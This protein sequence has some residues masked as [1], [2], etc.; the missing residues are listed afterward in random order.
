MKNLHSGTSSKLDLAA[1]VVRLFGAASFTLNGVS[2]L[3]ILRPGDRLTVQSADLAIVRPGQIVQF[4]LW[5][6]LVCHRVIR[7]C[8]SHL[9]T[10]GDIVPSPDPPVTAENL[11]GVVVSIERHGRSFV[12]PLRPG[13]ASRFTAAVLRHSLFPLRVWQRV[14]SLQKK[15][16]WQ[17]KTLPRFSESS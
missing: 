6:R 14:R 3:P 9:M 11:L 8:G 4:S 15:V 17:W 7:H 13:L 12:P 1:E 2:M 16:E 10:Q 5:G